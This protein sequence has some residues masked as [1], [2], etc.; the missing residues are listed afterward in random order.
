MLNKLIAVFLTLLFVVV[1]V[2]GQDQVRRGPPDYC[3]K[4]VYHLLDHYHKDAPSPEENN[5]PECTSWQS[6]SCCTYELANDLSQLA[7]HEGIYNFTYDL[8]GSLSPGCAQYF[9]VISN[10]VKISL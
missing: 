2:Q 7:T 6:S 10:E 4:G 9:K 8:C 5:F 1:L 3:I